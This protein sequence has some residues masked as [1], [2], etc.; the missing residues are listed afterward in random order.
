MGKVEVQQTLKAGAVCVCRKFTGQETRVSSGQRPSR[1]AASSFSP[2]NT[3]VPAHMSLGFFLRLV[4][5]FFNPWV[6][7][8]RT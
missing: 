2:G 6:D 1:L 5:L 7:A 3:S 4:I 8:H